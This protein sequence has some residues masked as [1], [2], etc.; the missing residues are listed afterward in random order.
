VGK[1]GAYAV[2]VC[3]AETRIRVLGGER[4]GRVVWCCAVSVAGH[5]CVVLFDVIEGS[6]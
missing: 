2:G 3:K 6:G 4:V 5:C 1:E